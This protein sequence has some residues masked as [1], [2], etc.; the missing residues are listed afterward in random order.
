MLWLFEGHTTHTLKQELDSA[1][2]PF[3]ILYLTLYYVVYRHRC[4]MT[5][6]FGVIDDEDYD[7][8]PKLNWLPNLH[9]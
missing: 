4:H 8:L 5:I 7:K 3:R 9:T 6:E 1:L 2:K